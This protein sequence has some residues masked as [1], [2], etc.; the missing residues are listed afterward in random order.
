MTTT[1][2]FLRPFRHPFSDQENAVIQ[3]GYATGF[4]DVRIAAALTNLDSNIARGCPRSPE[5]VQRRRSEL[6]LNRRTQVTSEDYGNNRHTQLCDDAFQLRMRTEIS[7][8]REHARI[9][10]YHD[11]SPIPIVPRM[12]WPQPVGSGCGSSAAACLEVSGPY[13]NHED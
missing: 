4:S 7:D 1:T 13:D 10:V 2:S 8:G 6:N 12:F 11:P 5:M 3:R 9:G